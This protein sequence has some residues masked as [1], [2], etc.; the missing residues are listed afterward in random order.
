MSHVSDPVQVDWDVEQVKYL[1]GP[2]SYDSGGTGT[3]RI[4][5]VCGLMRP[6]LHRLV[7]EFVYRFYLMSAAV[8]SQ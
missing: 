4:Y 6:N 8:T 5:G 7:P 2:I 1:S 3:R